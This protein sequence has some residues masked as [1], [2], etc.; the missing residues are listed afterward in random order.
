MIHSLICLC[1]YAGGGLLIY[2]MF[3]RSKLPNSRRFDAICAG[4]W[5]VGW[6]VKLLAA[7]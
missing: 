1:I 7:H 2:R 6:A 3:R 5:P 4:V